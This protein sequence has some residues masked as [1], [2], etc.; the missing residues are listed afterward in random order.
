[1]SELRAQNAIAASHVEHV[2]RAARDGFQQQ[3]V[4]VDIGIP[5]LHGEHVRIRITRA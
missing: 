5:K 1:V 4:M 2:L 3:R